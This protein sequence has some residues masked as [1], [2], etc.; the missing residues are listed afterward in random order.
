MAA[1]IAVDLKLFETAIKDE[2]RAKTNTEFAEVVG[3]SPDLVKR[4][5]R[6]CASMKMLEERGPG[7]YGP[8]EITQLLVKPEYEGGIIHKFVSSKP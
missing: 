8:T 7:V 5:T 2:G 4:I 1:R 3:A 6:A